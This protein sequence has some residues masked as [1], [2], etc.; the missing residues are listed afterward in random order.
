MHFLTKEE[1]QDFIRDTKHD[2][3]TTHE[4]L[5][6]IKI[7][8]IHRRLQMGYRFGN[9]TIYNNELIIEG[10]HRYIAYKMCGIEFDIRKGTK[11]HSDVNKNINEIIVDI[12][13]DWDYN[14]LQTR[15]YCND[16]FLQGL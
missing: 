7:Q 4:K 11:S 1:V 14:C 5:C 9:I 6:F 13:E 15:H 16:D 8:R 3:Y 10:N 2:F 12:D